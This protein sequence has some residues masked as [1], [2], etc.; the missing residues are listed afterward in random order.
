MSKRQKRSNAAVL[1]AFIQFFGSLY[2]NSKKERQ[3]SDRLELL[4]QQRREDIILKQQRQIEMLDRIEHRRNQVVL[5]DLEI[6]AKR[7]LLGYP[8][9]TAA[10]GNNQEFNPPNYDV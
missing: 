2:T 8:A 3:E 5:L 7:R 1:F 9:D 10:G 6:E 4:N